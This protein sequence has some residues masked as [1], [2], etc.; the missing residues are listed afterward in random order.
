MYTTSPNTGIPV[1]NPEIAT[2]TGDFFSPNIPKIPL[3]IDSIPPDSN[4]NFPSITPK[5]VTIP[6]L[7]R[8]LPNPSVTVLATSGSG[9]FTNTPVPNAVSKSATNALSLNLIISSSNTTMARIKMPINSGPDT[10]PPEN[11]IVS[12]FFFSF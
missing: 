8:V 1:I 12:S 9:M 3:E 2:A 5:P 6:I 7:P 4:M 11:I 10:I